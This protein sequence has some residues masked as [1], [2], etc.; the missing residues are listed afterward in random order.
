LYHHQL[1]IECVDCKISKSTAVQLCGWITR[2]YCRSTAGL[3]CVVIP[4]IKNMCIG[5]INIC[6]TVLRNMMRSYGFLFRSKQSGYCPPDLPSF[7]ELCKKSDEQ[8]FHQLIN[9][10]NHL[11]TDLLPK[12]RHRQNYHLRTRA[13]SRQLLK[14]F[15]HLTDSNFI[16]KQFNDIY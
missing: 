4:K 12:F 6:T 10:Q 11:L 8:F 1:I 14:H 3:A 7:R 2:V 5:L 15:G 13:H 16:T 9:Y